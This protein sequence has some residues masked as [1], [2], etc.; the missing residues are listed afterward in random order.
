V[1]EVDVSVDVHEAT[2][3]TSHRAQEAAQQDAAVAT[4]DECGSS[5]RQRALDRVGEQQAMLADRQAVPDAG[6]RLRLEVVRRTIQL[7]EPF[8]GQSRPEASGEHRLWGAPRPRL[9]SRR[10]RP[11][12]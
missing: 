5:R 3:P 7:D 10:G 1:E 11:K 9:V 12:T 4:Q 8:G 2:A 6:A